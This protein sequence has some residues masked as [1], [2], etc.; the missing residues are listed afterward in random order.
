VKQ[1]IVSGGLG[2]LGSHLVERILRRPDVAGVTIV[3]NLWTGTRENEAVFRDPRVKVAIEDIERF[4]TE[5]RFDEVY[6]LAS[7]AAPLWY[8]AAPDRTISANVAGALRLI[9]LAKRGARFCY[10]STSE[11]YGEAEVTPQP[12]SYRGSVDCTGPRSSYDE[13]KR[14]TESLLF[15]CSRVFG[16]DVRVARVFNVYG[17]RTRREDGRAISNFIGQALAGKPIT[18]FGDGKQMRSW[19][20]VDDII[21]GL[22]QWFWEAETDYRGPLN[23]G[24]D[25][26][27]SVAEI[28]RYVAS[29]FPRPFISFEPA[30]PQDPT[31]RRPDLTLA[32]AL[33]PGWECKT[34]YEIGIKQT[35]D[36][37]RANNELG[38][39]AGG[40][41]T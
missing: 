20:Y 22:Q 25:R 18:I 5:M 1:I 16:L 26:E 29:F 35:I 33:L 15:E 19:G 6:H 13:S 21:D 14:C 24:N 7:P 36:W 9:E 4:R 8:A 39:H 27:A 38:I 10:T 3:D 28:A 32:R 40:R 34:A 11:V 41:S 2:F 30:M 23:I 31:N 17:P 12:E 37:F